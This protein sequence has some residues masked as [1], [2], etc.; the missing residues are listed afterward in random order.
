MRP[1]W[2]VLAG[3]AACLA[4]GIGAAGAF[5]GDW[6]A[7]RYVAASFARYPSGD[8]GRNATAYTSPRVPSAVAQQIT[9]RWEPADEYVDGTGVYLRYRTDT[10]V[11]RPR[12]TGSLILVEALRTAYPRYHGT[13]GNYWGWGRAN[14]LR[15]G[16]PGAGK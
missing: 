11:V 15:G 12:G 6:S 10:V 5:E 9:D 4:L 14:G 7:R 16:G 8:L 13:V 3:I 2:W 1:V